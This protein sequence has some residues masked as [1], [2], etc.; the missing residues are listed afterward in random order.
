MPF[1]SIGGLGDTAAAKIVQ[2]REEGEIFS[3]EELRTRG[4]LSKS[5]IEL[6]RSCGTLDGLSETNQLSFF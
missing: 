3:V 2:I 4:G 5:I 1:N 6:L